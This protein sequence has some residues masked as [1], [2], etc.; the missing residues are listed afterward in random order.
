MNTYGPSESDIIPQG[1]HSLNFDVGTLSCKSG[2]SKVDG[3][4]GRPKVY[5]Y[6][7]FYDYCNEAYSFCAFHMPEKAF[8]AFDGFCPKSTTF[9]LQ[10]KLL[11]Q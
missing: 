2:E 6:I 8:E 5:G 3:Q 1:F 7:E 4:R 9:L 10:C 11:A